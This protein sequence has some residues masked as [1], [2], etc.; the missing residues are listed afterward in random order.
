LVVTVE[1]ANVAFGHRDEAMLQ[2]K[3]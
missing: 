2:A 3:A 1:E